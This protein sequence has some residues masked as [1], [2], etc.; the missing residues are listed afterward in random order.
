MR[1]LGERSERTQGMLLALAALFVLLDAAALSLSPA[2]RA[3][4]W[5]AA[6]RWDHWLGALAW[7]AV[8]ALARR[9]LA[10]RLPESDPLL[11]PVAALLSGWGLMTIW[12]LSPYLG[13]RQSLWL[14]AAGAAFLA[15]LRFTAL[16]E[17][18]RSYKYVWLSAGLLLT[19]LTLALGRNPLGEGPRMWLGCCGVYFQPSEPLKLLLLVY[20][21]AYLAALQPVRRARILP[22]LAPTLLMGGLASLLLVVQRDLG[23]ASIFLFLY[24]VVVYVASGEWRILLA[25]A[26]ALLIAAV[27]GLQLFDVVRVRVDAWL[28]PWLDPSGRSYQIVQ[29]L[30]SVANGGVFGRGPG[31]GSPTLTPVAHSDFIFAALSEEF[32]LAGALGMLALYAL[33]VHRGLRIA[34]RAPDLY[35]RCLAA[36][37]TAYWAG[38]SI[39]IIGGNLRLLPLTGVTL[40]LV[41]Y[42]GSSLLVSFLALLVLLRVSQSVAESDGEA[43]SETWRAPAQ[44][45]LHLG[46]F[47]LA[48]LG[49]AALVS[50][51]WG[52]VRGPALLERADNPRRYLADRYVLRGA[53]LDRNGAPLS[54]SQGAAGEY[55]RL[56]HYP[57]LSAT[58]GYSHPLFGQAGLEAGLDGYL[59]GLRGNPGLLIWQHHLLY[60][61]PPP[62]L[63]VRLTLD[64]SLQR[65]AD[66]ALA[67][68]TGGL[69]LLDARSGEILAL[70]SSPIFDAN[71]LEGDW[72]V[73]A[74]GESAPLLNRAVLGRYPPGE[75]ES[76]L[77]AALSRP[78]EIGLPGGEAHQAGEALLLSPLR[79]A[80]GAAA[81]CANGMI[82]AA[83]LASAVNLPYAGWVILPAAGESVQ[84]FNA[85]EAQRLAGALALEDGLLWGQ[86]AAVENG[87]A[88]MV[89]WFVGGVLPAG[90][91]G[92][93]AWDGLPFVLAVL[94]EEDAPQKAQQIGLQVLAAAMG[95]AAAP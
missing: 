69:A 84:A 72:E 86:A 67:G 4:T 57:P 7:L 24:T 40:P 81:L 38:Q 9:E 56:V 50:G 34:L 48:G 78:I 42:G 54:S 53:L 93:A 17:F 77:S 60:G 29:S 55:T 23:T 62:G 27:L 36:G 15:G 22:A 68:H 80:L 10:R 19:A 92:S 21:S 25:G 91:G 49:A 75:L 47:L 82:P 83:Q 31:M 87:E 66:E 32:G 11:L 8:M 39:L 14:L 65:A 51:W 18:L 2:A 90:A 85:R 64:L 94:I 44:P 71:R 70:A 52:F 35:R 74:Q 12:R 13:L 33:L 3:H 79:A 41:S 37:I 20:L 5:Q 58:L 46:A 6:L 45:V 30:L 61:Q 88:G 59:R 43:Q 28:N 1:S 16:L 26:L 89:S 95:G 76:L 63:D 73:L